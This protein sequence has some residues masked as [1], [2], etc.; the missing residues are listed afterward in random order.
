MD[1]FGTGYSSLSYLRQFPFDILK[2]DKSF[3]DGAGDEH[4]GHEL[5]AAIIELAKTLQLTVVAE[6]IERLE[7]LTRLRSLDCEFG[8]GFYFATPADVGTMD[9]LLA[10]AERD[11]SVA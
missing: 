1:D 10:A 6:G 2:I 7:Q 8:Q 5:T 4:N 3:I 11:S 9:E